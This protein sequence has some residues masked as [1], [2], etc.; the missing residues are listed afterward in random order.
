VLRSA[1][2][3]RCI[4]AASAPP[5][6]RPPAPGSHA[7]RKFYVTIEAFMVARVRLVFRATFAAVPSSLLSASRHP[8]PWLGPR[9]S[10]FDRFRRRSPAVSLVCTLPLTHPGRVRAPWPPTTCARFPSR[11]S[12][13]SLLSVDNATS[14]NAA[15]TSRLPESDGPLCSSSGGNS[16]A[17]ASGLPATPA[18]SSAAELPDRHPHQHRDP[19]LS[20]A[21]SGD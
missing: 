20:T 19:D 21:F 9:Y 17:A 10:A 3:P 13:W 16:T 4:Q 15:L 6:R 1:R 7:H 5:G 12:G 18:D 8:D 11:A 2:Y 14:H